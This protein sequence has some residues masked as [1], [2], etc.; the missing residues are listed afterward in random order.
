MDAQL[1][2]AEDYEIEA[3]DEGAGGETESVPL[4]ANATFNTPVGSQN[5][6]GKKKKLLKIIGMSL[7]LKRYKTLTHIMHTLC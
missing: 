4:N 2:S 6:K 3:K 7:G 5:S 1:R